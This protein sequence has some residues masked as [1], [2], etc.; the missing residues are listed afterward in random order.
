MLPG[1]MNPVAKSYANVDATL[2]GVSLEATQIL[3]ERWFLSGGVSYV[4][5]TK[6]PVPDHGIVSENLAEMPPLSARLALRWQSPRWFAEAEGVVMAEQDRI[7]PDLGEETTP[8]W[9]I[10]NL[11]AGYTTGPWQFMVVIDNL[12]D[13]TYFEHFSYFR[14]PFR[15]GLRLNE[16]GRSFSV[17]L[18]WRS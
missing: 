8:A 4:R 15:A 3:S 14:D 17:R 7:D 16:P 11:R 12:F 13:R 2:W 10:A 6:D 18:G 9:A 5:G 1:I